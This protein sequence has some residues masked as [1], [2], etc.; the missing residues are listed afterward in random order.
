MATALNEHIVTSYED[1]LINLNKAISEMGGMVE[2]AIT[3]AANALLKLDHVRAQN[4]RQ[5]DKQI[6]AMKN[7]I[8]DIILGAKKDGTIERLS[9]KW[10]GRPAG[11]L[12]L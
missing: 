2:Q 7:R 9:G 8:N 1:E 5:Y 3:E 12:P 6:D 4:V 10:L 11:E